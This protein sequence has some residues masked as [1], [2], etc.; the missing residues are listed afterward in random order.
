M[1]QTG[2]FREGRGGERPSRLRGNVAVGLGDEDSWDN[3]EMQA[4]RWGGGVEKEGRLVGSGLW[5]GKGRQRQRPD[6]S[7][8]KPSGVRKG[9]LGYVMV[10]CLPVLDICVCL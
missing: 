7:F 5:N 10:I 9:R 3:A 2:H 6:C 8:Q 1:E 4:H